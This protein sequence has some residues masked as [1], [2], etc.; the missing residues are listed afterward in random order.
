MAPGSEIRLSG[1]TPGRSSRWGQLCGDPEAA[2]PSQTV[3]IYGVSGRSA[4][5]GLEH[6]DSRRGKY[7]LYKNTEQHSDDCARFPFKSI[8]Q[9]L[10]LDTKV[11]NVLCKPST[12]GF[13]HAP[14]PPF[15]EPP[16]A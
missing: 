10:F 11:I 13:Y 15:I 3:G 4:K 16:L 2:P 6:W 12:H 9:R 8:P 5:M 7:V 14:I 1:G